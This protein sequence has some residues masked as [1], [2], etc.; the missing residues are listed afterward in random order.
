MKAMF[1]LFFLSELI[2]LIIGIMKF[3]WSFSNENE[4]SATQSVVKRKNVSESNIDADSNQ[5][6]KYL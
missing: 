1:C 6:G 2:G 5:I 4:I 3:L